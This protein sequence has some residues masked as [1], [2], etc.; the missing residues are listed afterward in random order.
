M[1]SG[2]NLLPHRRT[3]KGRSSVISDWFKNHLIVYVHI[4]KAKQRGMLPNVVCIVGRLIKAAFCPHATDGFS[5]LRVGNL[6]GNQ[7]WG[8]LPPDLLPQAFIPGPRMALTQYISPFFRCEVC[9]VCFLPTP[10]IAGLGGPP[11]GAMQ[12]VSSRH[13]LLLCL[14][15]VLA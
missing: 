8:N 12:T 15:L 2:V 4:S 5:P 6:S 3:F 14:V 1:R 7:C 13:R 11:I 9:T 10:T